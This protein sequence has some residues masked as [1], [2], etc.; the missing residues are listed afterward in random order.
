M[1]LYTQAQYE[2]LI[3]NGHPENR[4]KEHLPVIKLFNPCGAATWLLS[5]LD[6]ENPSIAFGLCDLGMGFP[7][8]GNVDLE[9]I[10][11]VKG[12]LGLGIERDFHFKP[13]FPLI[14][15]ARAAWQYNRIIEDENIL[16][17]FV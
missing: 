13:V 4:D 8:L 11:A 15:Y 7:E 6:P 16:N 17:K 12:P 9:E 1:K 3:K 5:E 14:V 2:R 10:V